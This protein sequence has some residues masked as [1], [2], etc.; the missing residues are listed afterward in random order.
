MHSSTSTTA[1]LETFS[2]AVFG[3]AAT[4]LVVALEVPKTY[5]ELAHS[6]YGFASFAVSFAV[7][8]VLWTIHHAYFR[9]FPVADYWTIAFNAFFLFVVLF[10]VYPLKFITES[11]FA[12]LFGWSAEK[13]IR[14][15][16][17]MVDLQGVFIIY[18]SGFAAV[19]FA[20]SLLYW[21]AYRSSDK[22]QL[23]EEKKHQAI[24]WAQHFSLYVSVALLSILLATFSIGLKF[25]LPGFI[26]IS[27]GLFAFLHGRYS[28]HGQWARLN[29]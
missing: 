29:N 4:L 1:R 22:F 7:L 14:I 21:H 27:L 16:T 12:S 26:Y 17:S 25:G 3:F 28:P 9:K 18:S 23:S 11:L 15:I 24:Y 6:M 5:Q 10:Y 8:I 20:V 2:D 13:H 19:F